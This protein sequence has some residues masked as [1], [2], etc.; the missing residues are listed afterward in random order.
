[1]NP[2][3]G[4]GKVYLGIPR[5]RVYIPAFVDNRDAILAR[6]HQAGLGSS[7]YQAEGHRVD[8][9]RDRIVKE[10]LADKTEPEWLLMI[11]TDME[12]PETLAERLIRWNK[13]IVGAL[14]FHRGRTHDPFAFRRVEDQKDEYGRYTPTW[15]P[16]RDEVYSYIIKNQI[17]LRDG[18]I[19]VDG[20]DNESLYECDA[21]ATG[22]ILIHRSV[23]DSIEAPW[24]EYPEGGISEDLWFCLK[25]KEKNLPVYCDF[26]TICGHYH[27]VPMGQVQF[28]MNY[29]NRGINLT[30]YSKRQA[31]E[32]IRKFFDISQEE[33]IKMIED[34]SPNDVGKLWES[35]FGGKTVPA[36]TEKEFYLSNEAGKTYIIELLHWNFTPQFT[37]LRQSLS[38]IR[39]STI[40]EIGSGIG[41]VLLQLAIQNNSVIGVEINPLL[42]SFSAMRYE[43]LVDKIET[44]LGSVEITDERWMV[45]MPD[46]SVDAVVSF[47]TFE[48][49]DEET[50]REVIKNISRVLKPNGHLIYHANW[51]QQDL[52]PMHHDYSSIWDEIL[53]SNQFT[54]LSDIEAVK[55]I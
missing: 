10:F 44:S 6:M 12:H 51:Y 41:S 39:N 55:N 27:W 18:A 15:A 50:L 30:T 37:R 17:P 36:A 19:V 21:V 53:K 32:W 1:M 8:R 2:G 11:D 47:D 54:P 31:A 43:E 45:E 4:N 14:Y 25:A 29:E 9:N 24:F 34:G 48:H 33:A 22:A 46:A 42:R 7:Y 52:Y 40:L 38:G 20:V 3:D 5:E 49:L 13:P 26:S 16:M 23:F 35:K 28:R